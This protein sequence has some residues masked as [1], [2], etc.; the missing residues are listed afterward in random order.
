V[1]GSGVGLIEGVEGYDLRVNLLKTL[2]KYNA[3]QFYNI[4]GVS[5][6]FYRYSITDQVFLPLNLTGTLLNVSNT[7]GALQV[8]NMP[9]NTVL[10]S[11]P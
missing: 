5:G 3:I 8:R 7:D 11:K 2:P 9:G 4:T 6:H 1:K 10:F